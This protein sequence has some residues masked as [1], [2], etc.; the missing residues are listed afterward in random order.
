MPP[1]EYTDLYCNTKCWAHL[2]F[3]Q[4]FRIVVGLYPYKVRR[5]KWAPC[6][7]TLCLYFRYSLAETVTTLSLADPALWVIYYRWVNT[8]SSGVARIW[9]VE[10]HFNTTWI[11]HMSWCQTQND[12]KYIYVYSVTPCSKNYARFNN[13]ILILIN[14]VCK[15]LK[16]PDIHKKVLP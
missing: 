8:S 11:C 12:T 15:F 6:D 5:R 16:I 7:L 14:V 1:C 3:E 13:K 10:E 2:R 4:C 9:R